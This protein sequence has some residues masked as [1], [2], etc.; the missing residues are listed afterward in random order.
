MDGTHVFNTSLKVKG[1][2]CRVNVLGYK[3]DHVPLK[4]DG[5][6]RSD[7]YCMVVLEEVHFSQQ[8]IIKN[9]KCFP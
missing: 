6:S 1:V 7:Q 2:S 3:V 4:S 8:I 9:Q 5:V